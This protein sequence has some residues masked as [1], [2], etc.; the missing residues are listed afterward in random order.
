MKKNFFSALLLCAVVFLSSCGGDSAVRVNDVIVSKAEK[1]V[2]LMGE[3]FNYIEDDDYDNALIYLDSISIHV[4]ESTDVISKLDNKSA[5][6]LKKATL[7]YLALFNDGVAD[8]KQAIQL[9]QSAETNEQFKKANTLISDFAKKV[10]GKLREV[11][12]AQADFAKAN[13][14]TLR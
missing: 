11:Q 4:K 7:E 5:E 9:F 1:A 8:Y 13:N 3:V 2:D 14:I 12:K 10:D 6:E